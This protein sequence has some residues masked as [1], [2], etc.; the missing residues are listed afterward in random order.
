MHKGVS[1]FM[2]LMNITSENAKFI[3]M[4]TNSLLNF[5]FISFVI[6]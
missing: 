3:L 2:I 5:F 6:S 1:F 4:L